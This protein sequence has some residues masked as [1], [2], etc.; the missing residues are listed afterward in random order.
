MILKASQR[1]GGK[2]LAAHLLNAR[3]NDHVTVHELRGFVADDLT[4]ALNEAYAVSR[5]TRCRQFLFS[6]SLSPPATEDVSIDMFERAIADIEAKMKLSEHPRAIVFHEKHGRRHA[7]CVWSRID[8]D[9]MTAIN[10]PLFKL[11]LRDMSRSLFL[12]NGWQMPRGLMNSEE[13]DPFT[14]NLAEWQQALRAKRDPR[15]TKELFQ[16]CWAVSDDLPTFENALKA[17]GFYLARGDR[18]GFV[19]IDWRGEVYSL[20]RWTGRKNKELQAK[21]GK[22]DQLPSVALVKAEIDHQAQAKT[23]TL[24][25]EIKSE[26]DRRRSAFEQERRNLVAGQRQERAKL[27]QAQERRAISEKC[28]RQSRLPTGVKALWFRLT[29]Q[30]APIKNAIEEEAEASRARDQS[31]WKALVDRQLNDRRTLSDNHR[32]KLDRDRLT[33]SALLHQQNPLA[34]S[35]DWQ[36]QIRR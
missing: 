2:Q 26:L 15:A 8:T 30:Y 7:H 20:S 12:E 34:S 33:A 6:L 18:R 25:D 19:A 3:D 22:S 24:L 27:K 10:L 16:E 36:L 23:E 32:R 29:G 35:H 1:A 11:K 28:E 5:G 14:F 17:R 31:E 13:R 9:S 4:G 21:L